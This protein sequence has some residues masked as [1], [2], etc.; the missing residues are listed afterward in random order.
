MQRAF[1]I[2]M[3]CHIGYCVSGQTLGGSS[4][5]N[6]LKIPNTPQLAA[7]A[8]INISQQSNDVGLSFNNPALLRPAMHSQ[9]SL[10]FTAFYAGIGDYQAM[11]AFRSE[12]WKT[13]FAAGVNYVQYGSITETDPA[14]N[15]M[16][17]LHPADYVVQL[18]AS[19]QYE[20]RWYYGATIKFIHSGYGQYSSSGAALD[21]GICYADT[22]HLLQVALVMKNM[23]AN[24]KAYTGTAAGDL[25]FD[26][27]AGI[28]KKLAHAPI[29]F[30]LTAHHMHQFD[31][32]YNDTAFNN[33]NGYASAPNGKLG[34]DKLFRHF[35]AA[36]QVYTGDKVELT[37]GYN[38][39]RRK[40]LN[41]GNAGNGLNGFS[42]GAGVILKKM[43]LR[44]A[45]S[46]YENNRA[47]HQFG[48]SLNLGDY[49]K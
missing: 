4:I 1:L 22:A 23:G 35:I 39:L 21:I 41:I 8:G 37:A 14:G 31:L 27:E 49:F 26:L 16:G 17:Q 25:P 36:V 11:A 28:S 19:R 46:Y 30:S 7:L 40:E 13:N 47:F 44:Y 9:A 45:W 33:S 48:F 3:L 32:L 6:F 42:F 2:S 5:Y 24:L 15:I 18:S 34:F 20:Q 29:Q 12:K 43:Q 38:Y 10:A